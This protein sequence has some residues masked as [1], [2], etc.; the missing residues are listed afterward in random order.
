MTHIAVYTRSA[1]VSPE[2]IEAQ[3]RTVNGALERAGFMKEA[4]VEYY[5]DD[6][7]SG[8]N[9][10]RPG[11]GLLLA[12]IAKGK[13]QWLVVDEWHRLSR[14]EDLLDIIDKLLAHNVAFI[15]AR[16]LEALC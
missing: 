4:T 9:S 15:T 13:F 16:E 12:D 8:M 2:N 1:V 5:S 14:S 11:L 7:A 6:G 10:E 3:R